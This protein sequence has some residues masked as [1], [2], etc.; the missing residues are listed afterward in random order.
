MG[1]V[2]GSEGLERIV[3]ALGQLRHWRSPR[4]D[5]MRLAQARRGT[6]L[7]H[8]SSWR[9]LPDLRQPRALSKWASRKGKGLKRAGRKL[10]RAAESVSRRFP[11]PAPDRRLFILGWILA[12]AFAI[13]LSGNPLE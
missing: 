7:R 9:E 10:Q 1:G 3:S 2:L 8:G 6:K 11:T 5:N 13:L 12:T 4:A